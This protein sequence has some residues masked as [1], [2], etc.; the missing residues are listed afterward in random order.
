MEGSTYTPS[1]MRS[2]ADSRLVTLNRC[3]HCWRNCGV[4]IP[5]AET[6]TNKRM[7]HSLQHGMQ[8]ERNLLLV[9]FQA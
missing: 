1:G 6:D 2:K 7:N 5:L 3:G 4:K 8:Q 9:D